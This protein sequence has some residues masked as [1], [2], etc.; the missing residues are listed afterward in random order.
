MSDQPLWQQWCDAAE[1]IRE[2]FGLH[3]AIGYLVGE[4]LVNFLEFTPN[5]P[6]LPDFIT[7]IR[8]LFTQ[9]E[10]SGYLRNVDR[11]G[12][13]GHVLDD[14]AYRAFT[15]AGAVAGSE[16]QAATDVIA[17]ERLK[18]LLLIP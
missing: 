11:L 10:L 12:S 18:R 15:R 8:Q 1:G 5:D 13:L 3:K 2:D 4:K 7:A 9:G 14:D 16:T 6:A 17:V